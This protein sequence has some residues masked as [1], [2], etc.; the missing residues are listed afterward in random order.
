M[1][2]EDINS[3]ENAFFS[4]Y[5]EGGF[6]MGENKISGSILI[7]SKG[8]YPWEIT[9]AKSITIEALKTIIDD[10][11]NLDFLMIG[12]GAEIAFLNKDVRAAL[13]DLSINVEAMDTGAA[14]RTYNV[15][16]QEGRK[17]GFAGI[18]VE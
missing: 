17:V 6:R 9:D 16:R 7:N 18:A 10:H 11:D 4:G 1:D 13:K 8:Y 15:L 3:Y 12:M 14:A 2:T 5:G